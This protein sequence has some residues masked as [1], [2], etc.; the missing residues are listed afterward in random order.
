MTLTRSSESKCSNKDIS[1][2]NNNNKMSTK[3]SITWLILANWITINNHNNNNNNHKFNRHC[4]FRRRNSILLKRYRNC[5]SIMR[6]IWR[7]SS[8]GDRCFHTIHVR[9]KHQ[10]YTLLRR[11]MRYRN[12]VRNLRKSSICLEWWLSSALLSRY[13]LRF[14]TSQLWRITCRRMYLLIWQSSS[15]LLIRQRR[16]SMKIMITI[17]TIITIVM[18]SN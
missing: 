5:K 16:M 18:N 3:D 11:P 4:L 12:M 10:N 14:L 6:T 8:N 1:I 13:I 15:R 7:R 2:V 9:G 17:T